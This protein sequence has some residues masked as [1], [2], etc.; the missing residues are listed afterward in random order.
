[1][2]F[3]RQQLAILIERGAMAHARGMALGGGRQIFHAVVDHLYRVAALFGEEC[4]VARKN[5]RIILFAAERASGF[6]LDH[7]DLVVREIEDAAQRFKNV[8]RALQRAPHRDSFFGAVLG[9]DAL[10][11][12][13]KMFLRAGA[14]LAFDNMRGAGPRGVDVALFQ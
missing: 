8:V 14:V 9:D 11:L 2:D 13:I 10:V 1:M 4:C 6:C 5:G 12:D 3:D 7:T